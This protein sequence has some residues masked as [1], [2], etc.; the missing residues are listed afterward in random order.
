M[1][2]VQLKEGA[3]IPQKKPKQK[4][5]W[6]RVLLAFF[7]GFLTFP[8]LIVGGGALIGTVFTT[9]QV[10]E[11]AG[12][13]PDDVLGAKYQSQTIL[14][15]VMTLINNQKYDTLED[16]NEISPMVQKTITETLNPVLEENFHY[17][18]DWDTL[19]TMKLSGEG[20]GSIGDYLKEDITNGIHLVDFIEGSEDLRGVLKYILYDVVKDENGN[21]VEDADGNVSIDENKPYSISDLMG[22]GANFFNQI[23]DYIKIGDVIEID[24]S[25]PKILQVMGDWR[26]G[27]ISE[28]METMKLSVLFDQKDLDENALIAAIGEMTVTD[29]SDGD[30]LMDTIMDLKLED[31][32]DDIQEDTLLYSFREKTLN[33]I[34]DTDVNDLY[35]TDLLKEEVY[36]LKPGKESEYNKVI[37]GI[38]ENERKDRYDADVVKGYVGTYEQWKEADPENAKYKEEYEKLKQSVE[39]HNRRFNSSNPYGSSHEGDYNRQM[40]GS[41]CATFVDCCFTWLCVNLACNMCCR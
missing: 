29:I 13:N 39:F 10:V 30:K 12:G 2:E 33:E 38:V 16:L 17:T 25:S 36:I 35:L 18:L 14:Q 3:Q 31:I 32:I 9:K 5:I 41:S 34:K 15:S 27:K 37:G 4:K 1:S 22:G 24:S 21:P 26:V 19:K 20:E 7:G 23:V 8:L 11:M 6:W 28:K 40:G